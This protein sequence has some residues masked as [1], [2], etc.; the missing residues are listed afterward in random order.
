MVMSKLFL[1]TLIFMSLLLSSCKTMDRNNMKPLETVNFVDINRYIGEWY[2][3]ARYEHKFQ[4]G[5]VG[6]KATYSLRDDGKITVVNECF[7]K[8]FSGNIRSVKGKA[9]VV[10]KQSNAKLKVSF[11]WPFSGDYWV[12]DL[13]ENYE[14]AVIGHPGRKYLWI[15]SRTPEMD[16][17]VY[18]EILDR[19]E[20]Q[21]YD[22]TKL[23]TSPQ[24]VKG[25]KS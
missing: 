7:E 4:K 3:V 9:W 19:L 12:I 21:D 25:G 15:L 11:F 2:E 1:F 8:S 20:K 10:D 14:Y 13:G 16:E 18:N 6:S 23:F 5:C 24:Q 17:N 22:T